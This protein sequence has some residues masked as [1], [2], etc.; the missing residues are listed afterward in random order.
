MNFQRQCVL[1]I[2][3]G[4]FFIIIGAYFLYL[5]AISIRGMG[6]DILNSEVQMITL[7]HPAGE[8]L[9]QF[10]L[11]AICGLGGIVCGVSHLW[12]LSGNRE[13]DDGQDSKVPKLK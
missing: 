12:Y 5:C 9:N 7:R 11:L 13:G 3:I 10:I 1:N 6:W 8:E 2:L 4:I